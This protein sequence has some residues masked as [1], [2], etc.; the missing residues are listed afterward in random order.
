VV[1]TSIGSVLDLLPLPNG[2]LHVATKRALEGY[3]ELLDPEL[4]TSV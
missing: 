1:V 3:S 2:A 4:R